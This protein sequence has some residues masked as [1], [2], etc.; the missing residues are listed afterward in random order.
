MPE[1]LR[2]PNPAPSS[3]RRRGLPTPHREPN[4]SQVDPAALAALTLALT[5]KRL[6]ATGHATGDVNV[7]AGAGTGQHRRPPEAGD[8]VD[9]LGCDGGW[10]ATDEGYVAAAYLNV[11]GYAGDDDDDDDRY[12]FNDDLEDDGEDDD[13]LGIDDNVAESI[14]DGF[15]D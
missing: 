13:P 10:C 14:Y 5:P 11:G 12:D 8:E 1:T 2:R 7:R 9:I 3:T 6:A 15:D 4:D